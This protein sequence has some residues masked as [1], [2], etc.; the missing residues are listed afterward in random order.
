M[1]RDLIPCQP[2]AGFFK[3]STVSNL[4]SGVPLR[5]KLNPENE[6]SGVNEVAGPDAYTV[7][8]LLSVVAT[9]LSLC[10]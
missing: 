7:A 3:Y 5:K 4:R 2:T 9:I 10:L 6:A 1:H 8:V